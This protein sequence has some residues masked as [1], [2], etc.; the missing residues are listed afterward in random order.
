[1]LISNLVEHFLSSNIIYN[2][3]LNLYFLSYISA[4]YS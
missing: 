1:M 3:N 4:F 2:N